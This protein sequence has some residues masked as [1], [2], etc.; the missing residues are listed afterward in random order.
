M[1]VEVIETEAKFVDQVVAKSVDLTGCQALGSVVAGAIL[2]AAAVEHV[3]ERRGQEIGVFAVTVAGEEIIF[4]ANGVVDA[5]V[6]FVFG[7]AAFRSSQVVS[8]GQT[9]IGRGEQISQF[10]AKRI[11]CGVRASIAGELVGRLSGGSGTDGGA[12]RSAIEGRT[13]LGHGRIENFPLIRLVAAAVE[14][15]WDGIAELEKRGE[16][17]ANFGGGGNRGQLRQCLPYAEAFVIPEEKQFVPLDGSTQR[18]AELVLL[19]RLAAE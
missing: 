14:H 13:G 11:D 12:A 10:L 8:T 3:V 4:V 17:S 7:F 5:N 16:I 1:R 19:V 15:T 18:K 9:G 6:K 2:K